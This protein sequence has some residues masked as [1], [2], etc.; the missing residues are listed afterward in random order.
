MANGR[1]NGRKGDS[2][3]DSGG[4]AAVPWSV[5]D[6]PAYARLSHPAKAL[7][8]EFARQFV[9][10]NNGRLL[11]SM[12][13]LGP[14]GWRSNDVITRAARELVAA[15]FVHQT[16]QG[17]RPNKASWYAVTW[18]TLDRHPGYDLGAAESFERG[19]YRKNALL[20]P[21]PGVGKPSIAPS[22]GVERPLTAPSPG[23]M[24]PIFAPTS[25]PSPGDHLEKPSAGARQRQNS[26]SKEATMN[27]QTTITADRPEVIETLA[28][29]WAKVGIRAMALPK[30]GRAGSVLADKTAAGRRDRQSVAQAAQDAG[31]TRPAPKPRPVLVARDD[32]NSIDRSEAQDLHAWND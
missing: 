24:E 31:I 8:M 26:T 15:G 7:L 13:H 3:R 5:L 11:C 6:S 1:G 27:M 18:R 28:D 2:G 19:S 10:D 9:R 23:A 20:T 17:Q 32:E 29:L 30:I 4:F 22:P 12:A 25:T 21:P 14:R 16:V